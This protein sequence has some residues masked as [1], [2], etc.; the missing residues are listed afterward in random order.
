LLEKVFDEFKAALGSRGESAEAYYTLG[1]NSAILGMGEQAEEAFRSAIRMNRDY[2][3]AHYCLGLVLSGKGSYTDAVPELRWALEGLPKA[4][5]IYRTLG[6]VYAEQGDT[7]K[8]ISTFQAGLE[9]NSN[10]EEA[11]VL[12]QELG[13]A[14]YAGGHYREAI[15]EL[16][17]AVEVRQRDAHLRVNLG[18]SYLAAG[19]LP[20]AAAE[21]RQALEITP[22]LVSALRNLGTLY[23]KLR[24]FDVAVQVLEKAVTIDADHPSTLRKLALACYEQGDRERAERHMRQAM[25][26]EQATRGQ[27]SAEGPV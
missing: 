8:A 6:R 4:L 18:A 7:D 2:W 25:E 14:Y 16:E 23:L 22:D 17:K 20:R 12:H 1:V 5:R 13:N 3:W 10:M 9:R 19:D 11:C 26:I 24:Q 21:F 27:A 15:A